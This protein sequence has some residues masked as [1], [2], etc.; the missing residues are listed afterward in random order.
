MNKSWF[1]DN[2]TGIILISAEFDPWTQVKIHKMTS[3]IVHI[4][5]HINLFERPELFK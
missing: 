5:L 3:F 4:K 2:D 1:G